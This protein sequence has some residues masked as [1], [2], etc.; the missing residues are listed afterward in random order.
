L[1]EEYREH[2]RNLKTTAAI[3]QA[4]LYPKAYP[5]MRQAFYIVKIVEKTYHLL[6]SQVHRG[7]I[8]TMYGQVLETTAFLCHH[9]EQA[10]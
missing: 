3:I 8:R 4:L 10:A 9:R 5:L 6:L 1:R 2:Q 7:V